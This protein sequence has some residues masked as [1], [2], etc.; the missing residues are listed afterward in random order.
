ML[1]SDMIDLAKLESEVSL[2]AFNLDLIVMVIWE[3]FC[4]YKVILDL[5]YFLAYLSI[6][7]EAVKVFNFFR[8]DKIDLNF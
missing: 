2:L 7:L 3:F 8:I 4:P 5:S 6:S 1:F